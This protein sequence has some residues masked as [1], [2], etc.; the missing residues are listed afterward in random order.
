MTSESTKEAKLFKAVGEVVSVLQ[1]K[2]HP[3][4]YVMRLIS[5]TPLMKSEVVTKVLCKK[6]KDQNHDKEQLCYHSQFNCCKGV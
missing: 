5:F 4:G 1:C 3:K 2:F 6:T